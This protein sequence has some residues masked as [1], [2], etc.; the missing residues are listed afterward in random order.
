MTPDLREALSQVTTKQTITI[1]ATLF[2]DLVYFY[3]KMERQTL[4]TIHEIDLTYNVD[5]LAT[6][7]AFPIR[8]A[9]NNWLGDYVQSETRQET[10]P[11]LINILPL[12]ENAVALFNEGRSV[13]VVDGNCYVLKNW[14]GAKWRSSRWISPEA[15]SVLVNLPADTAQAQPLVPYPPKTILVLNQGNAVFVWERDSYIFMERKINTWVKAAEVPRA[16][17]N[18]LYGLINKRGTDREQF[19]TE[20]D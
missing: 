3:D 6:A 9:L 7:E 16:A 8:V 1:P 15:A 13:F 20:S 19:N 17:L 2:R 10:A 5:M 18:A 12:P 14:T 4:S 11:H